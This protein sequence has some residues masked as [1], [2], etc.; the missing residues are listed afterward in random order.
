MAASLTDVLRV[1]AGP[2]RCQRVAI[3]VCRKGQVA[4]GLTTKWLLAVATLICWR[5]IIVG[6]KMRRSTSRRNIMETS[7]KYIA[8][9][10]GA[11]AVGAAIVLAPVAGADTDP[12]VP[13]GTEPSVAHVL[14]F[15]ESNHD[16][17]NTT[18]GQLDLPF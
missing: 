15:H 10:L 1:A 6:S 16:E 3:L 8:P 12:L 17:A 4:A 11:A 5:A 7:I 18:N 13:Y 14:G 9:W 2:N